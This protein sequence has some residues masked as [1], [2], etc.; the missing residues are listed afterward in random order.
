MT[1]P[2][3]QDLRETFSKTSE[4]KTPL[5]LRKEHDEHNMAQ[6]VDIDLTMDNHE[7]VPLM[8]GD[9]NIP[10]RPGERVGIQA[11]EC[12]PWKGHTCEGP[13][14]VMV[15]GSVVKRKAYGTACI[16]ILEIPSMC[17][18]THTTRT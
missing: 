5:A 14:T 15:V 3:F 18:Q 8:R 9:P 2:R 1:N 4:G 12:L 7:D 10:V 6:D 13:C 17:L 16:K 11:S